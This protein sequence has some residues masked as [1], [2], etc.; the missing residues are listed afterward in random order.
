MSFI[1][2]HVTPNAPGQ[3]WYWEVISD[4]TTVIAR[5]LAPTREEAETQLRKLRETALTV[6]GGRAVPS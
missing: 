1:E 2:H 3:G 6:G 4:F 5:G